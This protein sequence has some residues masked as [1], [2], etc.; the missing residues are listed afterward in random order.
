MNDDIGFKII[1]PN[2]IG[3]LNRLAGNLSKPKM[4][5]W[6]WEDTLRANPL[7]SFAMIFMNPNNIVI[8]LGDGHGVLAFSGVSPGWRA[9]L[10]AATWG[11]RATRKPKLWRKAMA[12]AMEMANLLVIE[13]I[14]RE[15]NIPALHAL[16]EAG[17]KYR[18]SIP[19]RLWY[20]AERKVGEWW[21]IDR[22]TLGLPERTK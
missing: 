13:A 20:N 9:S 16:K 6:F 7:A 15:D 14:T 11:P 4:I 19:D 12:V 5:E 17:F 22:V 2:D 21:E 3:E 1:R 8:D 18:G 10:Y